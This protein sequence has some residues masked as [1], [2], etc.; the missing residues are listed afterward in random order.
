MSK[1][2]PDSPYPEQCK[3]L[4][5]LTILSICRKEASPVKVYGETTLIFPLLVAETFARHFHNKD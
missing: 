2:L 4:A 1:T 3:Q 5:S